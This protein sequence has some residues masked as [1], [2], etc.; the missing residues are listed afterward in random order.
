MQPAHAMLGLLPGV[1]RRI[2][3]SSFS[4]K[5]MTDK[6]R[7][8]VT[9]IGSM[10]AKIPSRIRY[11]L[12][13]E[14]IAVLAARCG[15]VRS[16]PIA[17]RRSRHRADRSIVVLMRGN[18][19]GAKGAGRRRWIGSTDNGTRCRLLIPQTAHGAKRSPR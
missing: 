18:V 6:E 2:G 16:F 5:L 4:F 8:Q 3:W 9:V 1:M 13:D 11:H 12:D 17:I 7:H 19:C 10:Q 14:Q 15:R